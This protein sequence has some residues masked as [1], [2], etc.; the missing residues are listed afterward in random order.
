MNKQYIRNGLEYYMKVEVMGGE[1]YEYQMLA[2]NTIKRLVPLQ[3]DQ[4]DHRQYLIYAAS[5]LKPFWITSEKMWISGLQIHSIVD[6]LLNTIKEMKKYLL[7]ADNLVLEPECLFLDLSKFQLH[8]L[9]VPGYDHNI[10]KQMTR[11]MEYL[12]G[13]ID[14]EDSEGVVFA[15]GMYRILKEP[16][17][18]LEEIEDY[19]Q[20]FCD[21]GKQEEKVEPICDT[22]PAKSW[23]LIISGLV[24]ILCFAG[25]AGM[26]FLIY[27]YGI[28]EW[29]RN[30]L[31]L[32]GFGL[33]ADSMIFAIQWKKRKQ[34]K[35][36]AAVFQV[37]SDTGISR[38]RESHISSSDDPELQPEEFEETMLLN[39]IDER[40]SFRTDRVTC[41]LMETGKGNCR[42]IL[43]DKM[44][45]VI[46]SY[47]M[48]VDYCFKDRQ[49]SRF[50]ASIS[51]KE[52]E[53]YLKDLHSTNGTFVNDV[54]LESEQ[55]IVIHN[56][57][58]VQF[59]DLR[60]RFVIVAV[61]NEQ[62]S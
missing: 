55:E 28:E 56:N 25:S 43:I 39:T 29:K 40:K 13:K 37:R 7:T 42:E 58:W 11:L 62:K 45:F 1:E 38:I 15:Y 2:H 14:Y 5:G 27:G 59:A 46:G 57:D 61:S 12:L 35:E 32:A 48:G 44:P 3:L 6:G 49:I 24:W 19:L 4:V 20:Q 10:I 17:T 22:Q 26:L 52:G 53:W 9:Y 60:F 33:L 34:E 36:A 41:K 21:G 54:K 51:E 47:S 50:H 31:L 23:K 18:G 30:L 8:F 16:A